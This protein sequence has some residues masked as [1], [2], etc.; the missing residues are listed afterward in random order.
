[1]FY[2][3]LINEKGIKCIIRKRIF[4]KEYAVELYILK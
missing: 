3:K 2:Y 1:M 4:E